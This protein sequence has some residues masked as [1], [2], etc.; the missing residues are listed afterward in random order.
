MAI[1]NFPDISKRCLAE[2]HVIIAQSQ[3]PL[4]LVQLRSTILFISRFR[5][6]LAEKVSLQKNGTRAFH[7]HISTMLNAKIIFHYYANYNENIVEIVFG[8]LPK[9]F[10]HRLFCF[11][12]QLGTELIFMARSKL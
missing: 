5:Q 10:P 1:K 6:K 4:L 2:Q 8:A 9:C 12:F 7:I 3:K 11:F